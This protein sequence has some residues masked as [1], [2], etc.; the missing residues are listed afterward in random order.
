M[1]N[2]SQ[3]HL[4]LSTSARLVAERDEIIFKINAVLDSEFSQSKDYA[5]Y[6]STLFEELSKKEV[7]IDTLQTYFKRHFTKKEE[8]DNNS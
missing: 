8:N 6:V 4:L 5:Y 7:A 1:D 3:R 2:N